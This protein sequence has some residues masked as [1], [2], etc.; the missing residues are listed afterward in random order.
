MRENHILNIKRQKMTEDEFETFKNI[1]KILIELN[2]KFS[3]FS[4]M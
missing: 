2:Y 3:F 4:R 1:E